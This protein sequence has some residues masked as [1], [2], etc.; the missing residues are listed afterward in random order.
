MIEI[1]GLEELQKKLNKI[2]NL[3]H[4]TKPLMQQ[5]GD[6]LMGE[7]EDSFNDGKSPFGQK[8]AALKPSTAAQKAKKGKS[9]KPLI[10]EGKLARGWEVKAESRKVEVYGTAKTEKGFAYGLVHQFGTRKAGRG[11]STF[12]PARPFLP[13]NKSGRLA[14]AAKRAIKDAA[15]D[16]IKKL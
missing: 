2:A 14:E 5:I 12:I 1:R 9:E 16:F 7:I 13:V 4:N 3:G 11:K 8:W 15:I 6:E 10:R